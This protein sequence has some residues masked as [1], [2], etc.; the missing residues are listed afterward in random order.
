[1][2]QTGWSNPT[3]LF[4]PDGIFCPLEMMEVSRRVVSFLCLCRLLFMYSKALV[5]VWSTPI[6]GLRLPRSHT[7]CQSELHQGPWLHSEVF[8]LLTIGV[9]SYRLAV[10]TNNALKRLRVAQPRLL[11]RGKKIKNKCSLTCLLNKPYENSTFMKVD[12]SKQRLYTEW[13]S[14]KRCFDIWVEKR[15]ERK[16]QYHPTSNILTL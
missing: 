16:K 6:L 1:M 7:I 13:P 3:L 2:L 15:K 9:R 8:L 10:G 14:Q 12:V 11:R 4:S 5:F